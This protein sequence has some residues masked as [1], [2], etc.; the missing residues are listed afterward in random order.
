MAAVEEENPVKKFRRKGQIMCEDPEER[1]ITVFQGA[2]SCKN[3]NNLT[4]W[5]TVERNENNSL[6]DW[7][8]VTI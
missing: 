6:W 2:T 8:K 5:N 1:S 3:Q 7:S 4:V